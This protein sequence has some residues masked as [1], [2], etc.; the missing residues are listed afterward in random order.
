MS[1]KAL[2]KGWVR[3]TRTCPDCGEEYTK[4]AGRHAAA[5]SLEADKPCTRCRAN[6]RAAWDQEATTRER[7]AYYESQ[8]DER[9]QRRL[10]REFERRLRDG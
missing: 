9:A 7:W 1:E 4:L 2:P 3:V 8:R 5:R 10:E 6:D